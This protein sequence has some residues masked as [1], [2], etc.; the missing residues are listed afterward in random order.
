MAAYMSR[1]MQKK[2][3]SLGIQMT[4]LRGEAKEDCPSTGSKGI[5]ET[6]VD[7]FLLSIFI[8]FPRRVNTAIGI[9]G[10]F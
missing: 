9:L 4:Y 1:V 6:I 8:C 7:T 10:N 5:Q 2:F 3:P